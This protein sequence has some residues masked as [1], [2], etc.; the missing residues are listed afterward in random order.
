VR[1]VHH[2]VDQRVGHAEDAGQRGA[3]IVAHPGDQLLARRLHPALGLP[4]LALPERLP[5]HPAT[6]QQAGRHRH[7]GHHQADHDRPDQLRGVHE[8]A[9]PEHADQRRGDRHQHQRGHRR[10]DRPPAHPLQQQPADQRHR[11]R[12]QQRQRRGHGQ[13]GEHVHQGADCGS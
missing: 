12:E 11:Q 7:R 1:F 2:P 9:H 5:G 13:L 4:R 3:Q 10:D 6:Q 8:A